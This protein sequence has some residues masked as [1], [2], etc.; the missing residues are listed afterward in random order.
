MGGRL[1]SRAVVFATVRNGHRAEAAIREALRNLI[2]GDLLEGDFES[3]ASPEQLR[4][5]AGHSDPF[6][7]LQRAFQHLESRLGRALL[8]LDDKLGELRSCPETRQ[9]LSSLLEGT[10]KL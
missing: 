3:V 5:T 6:V 1:F 2:G 7:H 4:A 10:Q 8:V 9:L